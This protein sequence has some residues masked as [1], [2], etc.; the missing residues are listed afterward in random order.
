MVPQDPQIEPWTPSGGQNGAKIASFSGRPNFIGAGYAPGG[1]REVSGRRQEHPLG[2]LWYVFSDASFGISLA[3]LFHPFSI[4]RRSFCKC[5]YFHM[6]ILSQWL[7][8]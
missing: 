3:C 1:L 5:A 4:F 2:I 8:Q 7:E 6:Q